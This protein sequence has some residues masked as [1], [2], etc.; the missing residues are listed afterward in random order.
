M[1]LYIDLIYSFYFNIKGNNYI[2]LKYL[3]SKRQIYIGIGIILIVL[4]ICFFI[5]HTF[6]TN[7]EK[8]IL[9]QIQKG[10]D[11]ILYSY[12][13]N[14]QEVADFVAILEKSKF[15]R[16]VS[17]PEMR[18]S[19]KSVDIIINGS[20]SI[21]PI[22]EIYYDT[23][24][25]YISA[26]ISKGIFLNVRYRISNATQVKEFIENIVNVKTNEFEIIP[27]SNR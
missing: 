22:I 1:I 26:N 20:G 5:P 3:K 14:E 7:N 8:G 24:R 16:G 13:L 11:G 9:I 27:S 4:I 10:I 15:Y 23:D 18:F 25:T 21:N 2:M 6:H 12:K 19:D 17:E